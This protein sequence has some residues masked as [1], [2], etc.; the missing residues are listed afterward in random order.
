MRSCHGLSQWIC[1]GDPPESWHSQ[2]K[3]SFRFGRCMDAQTMHNLY[4]AG[5]ELFQP[6]RQTLKTNDV[7]SIRL[8]HVSMDFSRSQTLGPD[9]TNETSLLNRRR[10]LKNG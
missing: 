4:A 3:C 5:R 8:I 6:V 2:Q 7:P 1:P 9:I 10:T